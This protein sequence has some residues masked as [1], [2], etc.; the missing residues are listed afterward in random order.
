MNI[1]DIMVE[2]HS[3]LQAIQVGLARP[4]ELTMNLWLAS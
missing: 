1:I 4:K 2:V 3:A